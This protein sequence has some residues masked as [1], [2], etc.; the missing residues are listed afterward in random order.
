MPALNFLKRFADDVES[1]HKLHTIRAKRKHPI[2]V[3]DRLFLNT[4]MRTKKWFRRLREAQCTKIE[5]IIITDYFVYVN[6]KCLSLEE[7]NA[8]ARADGFRDDMRDDAWAVM[9][10]F[11]SDVHGL[12]FRGDLIHWSPPQP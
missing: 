3:G 1:G 8:L 5:E 7:M 2:K 11:F 4:G 6:E 9:V 10:Q 12:P